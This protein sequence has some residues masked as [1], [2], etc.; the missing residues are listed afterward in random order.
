MILYAVMA[1]TSVVKMFVAGILPGI[2][3]A[4]GLAVAAYIQALRYN[5]P[6]EERFQL[7]RV[8]QTFKEA[9]WAFMLPVIIL[10]GIFAGFVT[11]TEGA[12]TRGRRRAV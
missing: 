2:L 6:V 12:G 10:G 11:A 9:L 5:F 8:W 7:A 3:G 1:Q 4:A